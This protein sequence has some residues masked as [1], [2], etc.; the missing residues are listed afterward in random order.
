MFEWRFFFIDKSLEEKYRDLED[1]I[2]YNHEAH[3]VLL[4]C[5][6]I[7]YVEGIEIISLFRSNFFYSIFGSRQDLH[8]VDNFIKETRGRKIRTFGY[9][10]FNT[11]YTINDN[12]WDDDDVDLL[13]GEFMRT[14]HS[15]NYKRIYSPIEY[16]TIFDA[17]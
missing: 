10:N 6:D 11:N 9:G 5:S 2:R 13:L 4:G 7:G 3:L 14:L 17:K 12:F 1:N 16:I 15:D 8:L